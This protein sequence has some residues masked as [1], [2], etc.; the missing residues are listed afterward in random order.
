[1][2]TGDDLL[3]ALEAEEV[4][5]SDAH[6][7]EDPGNGV[8]QVNDADIVDEAEHHGEPSHTEY[9]DANGGDNG[10]GHGLSGASDGAAKDIGEGEGTG[11]GGHIFHH[12][13]SEFL[14]LGLLGKEV[15]HIVG[16]EENGDAQ[17]C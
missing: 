15:Q 12:T 13:Q 1:M 6:G 2:D 5:D 10:D 3:P 16:T 8:A 17:Q 4:V 14:D 7:A 9:A 11:E